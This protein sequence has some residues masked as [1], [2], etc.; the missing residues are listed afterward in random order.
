M[1]ANYIFES[2]SDEYCID[3]S[4]NSNNGTG[5]RINWADAF[6]PYA[7]YS[8]T[9]LN[10][11]EGVWDAY[12]S[13]YSTVLSVDDLNISAQNGIAFGDNNQPFLFATAATLEVP[14][15]SE[16]QWRF[17]NIQNNTFDINVNIEDINI[18]QFDSLCIITASDNEFTQNVEYFTMEVTGNSYNFV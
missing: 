5:T 13:N 1:V 11:V 6:Y 12:T 3:I 8:D 10:N 9:Y 17:E 2:H 15:K 7:S 14:Y 4:P 16:R 18:S